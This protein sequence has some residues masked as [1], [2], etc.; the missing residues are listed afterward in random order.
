[1]NN[2]LFIY[3]LSLKVL[4]ALYLED[5]DP[6]SLLYKISLIDLNNSIS[7]ENIR[8]INPF[9]F[10][11]RKY[12]LVLNSLYSSFLIKVDNN[13]ISLTFDGKEIIEKMQELPF[14]K[15]ILKTCQYVEKNASS[16]Y[17]ELYID[18]LELFTKQLI[19][20]ERL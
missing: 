13:K 16:G 17:R 12:R 7:S 18:N 20:K 2:S 8:N 9:G 15:S 5:L 11:L 1:M 3:T 6:I 19:A 10:Y 4:T 14:A